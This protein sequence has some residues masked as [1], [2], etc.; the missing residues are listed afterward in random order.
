M[1]VGG[2]GAALILVDEIAKHAGLSWIVEHLS[3]VFGSDDV[4]TF[5]GAHPFV[6][7]ALIVAAWLVFV[8]YRSRRSEGEIQTPEI[9]GGHDIHATASGSSSTAISIKDQ[10]AGRDIIQ[11]FAA[12][13]TPAVFG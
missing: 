12:P 6:A 2:G 13:Q 4:L 8:Y 5:A 3:K 10:S 1:A 7:Y 11:Y 9:S